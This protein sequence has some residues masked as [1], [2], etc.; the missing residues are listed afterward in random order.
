VDLDSRNSSQN[1]LLPTLIERED[2]NLQFSNIVFQLEASDA[3]V[4]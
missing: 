2:G 4:E 3:G 1:E